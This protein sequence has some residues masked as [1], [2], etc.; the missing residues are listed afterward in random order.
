MSSDRRSTALGTICL[1]LGLVAVTS[2]QPVLAAQS[3]R[4]PRS[5]LIADIRELSDLLES[6]HPDPY[7]HGGGRIAYHLGLQKLIRSIPEEGLSREDFLA[8][9]RPF[10]AQLGDGHTTLS[11]LPTERNAMNPGGVPL[12]FE[13]IERRL[14]VDAVT[15]EEDRPLIG[16]TLESIEGV[17]FT[18]ILA[19]ESLWQGH[20]NDEHVLS[21]L[22]RK[23]ALYYADSLRR[24]LP[25]W[26]DR[27]RI[28]VGLHNPGGELEMH[29]LAPAIGVGDPPL[30]KRSRIDLPDLPRWV[31]YEFLGPSR[32][33]AYLWIHNMTTYREMFEYSRAVGSPGY[34]TWARKVWERSHPGPSPADLGEVFAG[35]ASATET[36][37]SLFRDMKA[38]SSRALIID[39]RRNFGGNDLMVP[40][41]LY[42]LVGF[43]RTVSLL[44]EM[45]EIQ[46]LSALFADSTQA[47]IDL[48]GISY[49]GLV[50][51][52]EGD[53]DFSLDPRFMPPGRGSGAVRDHYLRLFEKSP[54][55]YSV[56][57]SR[58]S[59]ASYSPERI[60]VLSSNGT[61]S[62]G[63]DLLVNLERLGAEIV[64]V[65]ASQ[66]GNGFG[67]IR[68]FTLRFSQLEGWISTKY[69]LRFP[70]EAPIGYVLPPS[71]PL[72]YRKL[73]AFD[74]DP[75]ASLLLALEVLGI[76][77]EGAVED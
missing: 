63:F 15:R 44:G 52:R 73:A 40:I 58:E 47:G 37:Q 14:Y 9:L 61:Q 70:D 23:G 4:L 55:F 33:I 31:G 5:E 48:D 19:R 17:A 34:E 54:T 1:L 74:F 46:R 62:S 8:V 51:L 2:S 69:F 42:F 32:E 41:F 77:G 28:E 68:H 60:M 71:H 30:R 21:A 76:D 29:T 35:I 13:V 67:N 49:A 11:P 59:E 25:E 39:L 10:V 53:Y 64:G 57:E 43:D 20:D 22:A 24:L 66:A 50:P 3:A 36:F 38:S 56:F 18:E 75:N 12:L 7:L 65:P 27:S 6:A 72:T 26:Q 45:T 16:A